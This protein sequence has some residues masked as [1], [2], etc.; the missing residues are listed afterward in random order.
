M[1]VCTFEVLVKTR[2]GYNGKRS[3]WILH[4]VTARYPF[5]AEP[6]RIVTPP[7]PPQLA[8]APNVNGTSVYDDS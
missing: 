2:L 5:R 1:I 4:I 6:P 8:V 3:L 7:P